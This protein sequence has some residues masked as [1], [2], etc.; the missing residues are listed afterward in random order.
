VKVVVISEEKNMKLIA[1]DRFYTKPKLLM[2]MLVMLTLL[3]FAI[4]S[5]AA[6]NDTPDSVD[7]TSSQR[8]DH[9]ATGYALSGA[10]ATIADCGSCHVGG[11]FKGTPH[12]CIGCHTKGQRVVA[13]TMSSNHLATTQP[14]D[15][16]HTNTVTF[17]GA[18][19]NHGMAIPGQC[20]SCHNGSI[21]PGR[22]ASHAI[23]QFKST[24]SCDSCH[25]P[26]VWLP[27][28]W[29]HNGVTG[30][31]IS[32]HGNAAMVGDI[33]TRHSVGGTSPEGYAH[34]AV[35]FS[36]GC[37][38]CHHTFTNW[39]GAT[40]N[41]VGAS[42]TC[43]TC[44]NGVRATPATPVT[45]T[46]S[47]AFAHNSS[48]GGV[49]VIDC[50]SCHSGYSSWLGAL[51]NHAGA[52]ST[53]SSCHNSTRATGFAQASALYSSHTTSG[54]CSSCHASTTTWLG[55]SGGKP[56]NHVPYN[57]GIACSACHLSDYVTKV[58]STTLH[59]Y[60]SSSSCATCHI[61]PNAY[62]GSPNTQQTKS[63]HSGSSGS[64][65]SNCHSQ[66]N[67]YTSWSHN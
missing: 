50:G 47:E 56:T 6:Q 9:T 29:N 55:A 2:T 34:S 31:C 57:G 7:K 53:C 15:I 46:S 1:L 45:G 12:N 54:E 14:C 21:A 25:R 22:P 52:S 62:T 66:A 33:N 26:T 27:S 37:E 59:T 40:F 24:Y 30:N 42:G 13:L 16:C 44:H 41:H 67:S 36:I 20:G 18:R 35:N 48:N 43:F 23:N 28:F 19:F 4:H 8:F 11:V 51:Y 58:A 63:S 10:H 60:S 5:I 61:S 17:L 3:M 38:S 65:C 39:Y 49:G 32:C 64:N